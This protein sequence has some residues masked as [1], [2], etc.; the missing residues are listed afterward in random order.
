[1]KAQENPPALSEWKKKSHQSFDMRGPDRVSYV[2]TSRHIS[3]SNDGT[4]S[5]NSSTS[6]P[7]TLN[8]SESTPNIATPESMRQ[9]DPDKFFGDMNLSNTE[10]DVTM[11]MGG[12]D[13]GGV[14]FF[15]EMLGVNLNGN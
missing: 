13:D 7:G 3:L 8:S 9:F 14:E 10:I 15:T 2:D 1:M 12:M 6:V 11:N 5:R 4:P